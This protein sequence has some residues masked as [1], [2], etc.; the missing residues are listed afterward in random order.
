MTGVAISNVFFFH[1]IS[2]PVYMYVVYMMQLV[3]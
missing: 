3:K 2:S 1:N